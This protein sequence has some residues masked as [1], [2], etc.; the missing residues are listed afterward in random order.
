MVPVATFD[1]GKDYG[2]PVF[3]TGGCVD[4]VECGEKHTRGL[5]QKAGLVKKTKQKTNLSLLKWG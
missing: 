1:R 2:V 3:S 5:V 4:I